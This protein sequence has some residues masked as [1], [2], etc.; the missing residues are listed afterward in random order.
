M[1]ASGVSRTATCEQNSEAC[2][3]YALT[4]KGPLDWWTYLCILW[5]YVW[6]NGSRER[7][8]TAMSTY[9]SRLDPH[10]HGIARIYAARILNLTKSVNSPGSNTPNSIPYSLTKYMVPVLYGTEHIV[11][12]SVQIGGRN[13][14]LAVTVVRGGFFISALTAR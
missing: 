3:G 11:E 1:T 8:R 13:L 12:N 6:K 14:C 5:C 9:I 4:V 10:G 2:G 7:E